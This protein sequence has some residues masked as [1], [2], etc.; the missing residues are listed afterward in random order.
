MHVPPAPAGHPAAGSGPR[1]SDARVPRY[2]VLFRVHMWDPFIERQY[3][4]LLAQVSS[5]DVF[6]VANNTSGQCGAIEGLPFVTFTE[7]DLETM[8]YARAGAKGGEFL[9]YNVDYPLYFFRQRYPDYD[10]Y[11]LFEYDVVANVQFDELVAT[12][13]TRGADL[14]GL[15]K[16]EPLEEWPFRASCDGIYT[17]TEVRKMLLPL[18]V[19]SRRAV[20]LLSERRLQLSDLFRAGRIDHWPYCEAFMPTELFLAGFGIDELSSYGSTSSLDFAP[21]HLEDDLEA[22]GS[23]G[24][25]HPVLDGPRYIASAIK[26]E[27]KP[28]RFFLRSHDF[29]RRLTRFPARAYVKPLGQAFRKRARASLRFLLRRIASRLPGTSGQRQP[30]R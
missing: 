11:I 16:G 10:Y 22:L 26:Y 13:R 23:E 25:V 24:F 5:G 17:R 3:R 27:H 4:R 21:A 28:E 7:G 6:I 15:T 2:A 18:G 1:R 8:G 12:A 14:I 19:F 20:D 29:R 30:D 9:W